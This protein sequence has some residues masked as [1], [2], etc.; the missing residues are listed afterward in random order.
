M[1]EWLE[2]PLLGGTLIYARAN[3]LFCERTQR[4]FYTSPLGSK[5]PF[6]AI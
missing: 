2:F 3:F 4:E 1:H 5:Q 6:A